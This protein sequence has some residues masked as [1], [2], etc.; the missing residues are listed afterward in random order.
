MDMFYLKDST[1]EHV[2]DKRNKSVMYNVYLTLSQITYDF[3]HFKNISYD[4]LKDQW[5]KENLSIAKLNSMLYVDDNIE[6][7][8]LIDIMALVNILNMPLTL[9]LVP[10]NKNNNSLY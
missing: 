4:D 10:V 7:V 6:D 1:V 5:T 2:P 3:M 8:T 9:E